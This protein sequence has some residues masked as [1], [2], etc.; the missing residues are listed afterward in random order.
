MFPQHS[1]K[2]VSGKSQ[3]L[4]QQLRLTNSLEQ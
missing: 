3:S 1:G 2:H 4:K